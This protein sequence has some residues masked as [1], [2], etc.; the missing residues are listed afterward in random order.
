MLFHV[1]W[2]ENGKIVQRCFIATRLIQ[3]AYEN[4]DGNS[5]SYRNNYDSSAKIVNDYTIKYH[6]SI[7]NDCIE[8]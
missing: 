1:A 8:N 3:Q 5:H 4:N 7:E 6:N 2:T